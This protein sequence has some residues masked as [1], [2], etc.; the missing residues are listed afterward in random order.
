MK[1][2]VILA[3]PN[4]HSFTAAIGA[5]YCDAVLSHGHVAVVRDLY[6]LD[7]DPRLKTDEIPGPN[8]FTPGADVVRERYELKDADVFAMVY[9]LWLNAPPAIL[10]G[11]L[12][13]VFG[14]GFAYGPRSGGADA[15]LKG[16]K[17]ISFSCSGAPK[18][19][20]VESGAWDAMRKLFDEHFAAV[21]GME[22]V[23]HVHF[24][25]IVSGIRKDVVAR[26]LETVRATVAAH[27]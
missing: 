5:A 14:M 17:L 2:A 18:E 15:L 19:W 3:H 1:H 26:H 23:D 6:A 7:F 12:E 22:V 21:C 4:S 25:A 8:G 27:F 9:P 13:R 20:V 11:Y 16:R 10:K 24:G